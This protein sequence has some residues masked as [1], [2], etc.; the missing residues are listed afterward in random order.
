[1]LA[2][3]GGDDGERL[4]KVNSVSIRYH[5]MGRR[6]GSI[7][8]VKISYADGAESVGLGADTG[9][10]VTYIPYGG[11]PSAGALSGDGGRYRD[12]VEL[13]FEIDGEGGERI[14]GL[15][16]SGAFALK[17]FPTGPYG[18]PRTATLFKSTGWLRPPPAG[19]IVD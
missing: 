3:Y 11:G 16:V 9:R 12:D 15:S 5:A 19:E 4:N 10:R 7:M 17:V 14:T 13:R 2:V 6:K 8:G 18:T 1:M